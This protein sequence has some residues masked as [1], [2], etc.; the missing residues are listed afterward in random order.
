MEKRRK[1]TE[2]K[3]KFKL[4]SSEKPRGKWS[5]IQIMYENEQTITH[6]QRE[7]T[8]IKLA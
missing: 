7:S 6:I 4:K 8:E 5:E 3:G 1:I 2:K